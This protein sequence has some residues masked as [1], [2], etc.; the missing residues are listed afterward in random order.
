M[1]SSKNS[2][3]E[4]SQ[5]PLA[6]VK[7]SPQRRLSRRLLRGKSNPEA[8][9][10]IDEITMDLIKPSIVT[11]EKASAVKIFFETYFNELINKPESR[12]TRRQYLETRLLYS[13]H[14]SA[15]Q[16]ELVR[17]S[18]WQQ[19]SYHLRETR[20]LKSKSQLRRKREAI[21]YS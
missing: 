9:G 14:L 7:L 3:T 13:P 4:S 18:S 2:T 17:H 1:S 5:V 10:T 19:E 12:V 21:H 6:P 11:S 20:V 16:K 8:L 15:E